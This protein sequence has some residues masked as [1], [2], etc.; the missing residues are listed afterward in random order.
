MQC[1]LPQTGPF[2]AG[3]AT[4]W[5][6]TPRL[7]AR[8][9]TNIRRN[10]HQSL[11]ICR[12]LLH[13][14]LSNRVRPM[15]G[16]LRSVKHADC[17]RTRA[18]LSLCLPRH[19]GA[20]AIRWA[21]AAALA[22]STRMATVLPCAHLTDREALMTFDEY[23]RFR[24]SVKGRSKSR[25]T[26]YRSPRRFQRCSLPSTMKLSVQPISCRQKSARRACLI[27]DDIS[28]AAVPNLASMPAL[29]SENWSVSGHAFRVIQEPNVMVPQA[30]AMES[31]LETSW[32]PLHMKVGR[33]TR[34]SKMTPVWGR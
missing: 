2:H 14:Y 16:N 28:S 31:L 23:P 21:Q 7:T 22:R 33:H 34:H 10:T 20:D 27:Y 13:H 11:L 19:V 12:L 1:C 9:D 25:P 26:E 30:A 8:T 29:P 32:L 15:Y 24:T 5:F 3:V 17:R 18:T 4:S 6:R